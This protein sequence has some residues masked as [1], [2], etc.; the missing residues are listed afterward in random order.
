MAT[1]SI[2][3]TRNAIKR[4]KSLPP[5][6]RAAQVSTMQRAVRIVESDLKRNSFTGVKSNDPFWGVR[7]ASGNALGVRSGHTRNSISGTVLV[8]MGG[9]HVQGIVGSPLKH[10]RLHEEG[11]TINGSP[12]LRIP[13]RVMQTPAG[14]DRLI[15]VSARSLPNTAVIRSKRNLWIVETGTP[16][17]KLASQVNG[18]PL[19]LYLL[20]RS[21]TLR[22]RR[23]FR[24]SLARVKNEVAGMF[25]GRVALIVRSND[26]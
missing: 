5:I 11:G 26:A 25:T 24:Q 12:Y 15:G 13:T 21:I 7:G 20:K 9:T 4:L 22:P 19:M 16:R 8:G 14:V 18:F 3:S 10:V 6:L 2:R 17:S 23:M 1:I